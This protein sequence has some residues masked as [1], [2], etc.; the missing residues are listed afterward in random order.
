M[1]VLLHSVGQG[2]SQGQAK[3][4]IEGDLDSHLLMRIVAGICNPFEFI[5]HLYTIPR[6]Y[7]AHDE[8]SIYCYHLKTTVNYDDIVESG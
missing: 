1:S 5:T 8:Q 2:K 7:L 3:V 4:G 6:T